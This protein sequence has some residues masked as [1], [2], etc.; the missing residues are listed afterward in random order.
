[1]I[2]GV[3]GSVTAWV[4]TTIGLYLDGLQAIHPTLLTLTT[5][6]MVGETNVAVAV[7]QPPP[8]NHPDLATA[9]GSPMS[10]FWAAVVANN[11]P[12]TRTINSTVYTAPQIHFYPVDS[13]SIP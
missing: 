7:G 5:S 11:Q 13:P 2:S 4:S 12:V 8:V 10:V 6:G 1:E 9:I 3:T